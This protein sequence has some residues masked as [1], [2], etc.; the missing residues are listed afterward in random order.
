M[1]NR[2]AFRPR[3]IQRKAFLVTVEGM[4]ELRV[5]LVKEIRSDV[6]RII[7]THGRAF[8]FNHFRT[9]IRQELRAERPGSVL[10]DR[11]DAKT[12]KR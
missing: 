2:L 7:A 6:A 3:N 5:L 11:K 9:L 12:F 10:L 4:E 1:K 8:D